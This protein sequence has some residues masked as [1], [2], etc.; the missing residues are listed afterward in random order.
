[1]KKAK[2]FLY[3]VSK[4]VPI[5]L[6]CAYLGGKDFSKYLL[7]HLGKL[8]FEILKRIILAILIILGGD[9]FLFTIYEPEEYYKPI[10]KGKVKYVK[11][12]MK[13]I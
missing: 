11:G 3:R 4:I 12:S 6:W 10:K 5:W 8:L 9:T 1:M 13:I 2:G 7:I